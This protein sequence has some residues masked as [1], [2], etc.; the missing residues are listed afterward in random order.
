[1]ILD[2]K[3]RDEI[4]SDL[5]KKNVKVWFLK[6]TWQTLQKWKIQEFTH[7]ILVALTLIGMSSER[8]K[9]SSLEPSRS[10]FYK[11]QWA[12]HSVKLTRL[13]SIFTSKKV[14]EKKSADKIW[15]KKDK[16]IESALPRAN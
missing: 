8:K 12:L 4:K 5:I 6:L 1:M 11:T 2:S 13:M 3:L 9:S 7:R 16:G 15:S 14:F 10:T